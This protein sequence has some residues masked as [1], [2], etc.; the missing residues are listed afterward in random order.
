VYCRTDISLTAFAVYKWGQFAWAFRLGLSG[1]AMYALVKR[2]GRSAECCDAGVVWY[3]S[4]GLYCVIVTTRAGINSVV[5]AVSDETAK[6]PATTPA[7]C[8]ERLSPLRRT[9]VMLSSD[10]VS[11]CLSVSLPFCLSVCLSGL[12]KKLRKDFHEFFW[13][14]VDRIGYKEKLITELCIQDFFTRAPV[15]ASALSWHSVGG[16][17]AAIWTLLVLLRSYNI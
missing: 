15:S 1:K 10:F 9:E 14:A 16:A 12:L 3:R 8:T 4:L 7:H 5:L 6:N 17:F 2:I 13:R 11:V